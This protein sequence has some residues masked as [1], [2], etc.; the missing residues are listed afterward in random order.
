MARKRSFDPDEVLEQIMISFWQHGFQETGLREL[1][2][3]TGVQAQ[4]LYNAFGSKQNL[5]YQ[6][7]EHYVSVASQMAD[8]I[9]ATDRSG[10]EKIADLLVLDWGKLP[11]PAGCMII[12]SLGD[13]DQMADKL[14]AVANRLSAHLTA[15]FRQILAT[16]TTELN[17][18]LSLD[19]L[20][21]Q[22]LTLHDGIQVSVQDNR[23][24]ANVTQIIK[25]TLAAFKRPEFV[26]TTQPKGEN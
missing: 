6:A 7:M 15:C 8:D 21:A 16:M 9:V 25:T 5:Y 26:Q 2:K 19:G 24:S 13:V 12:S 11:Y 20:A 18:A 4:S 22:L 14:D 1:T 23:Y 17:P 10:D 3:A